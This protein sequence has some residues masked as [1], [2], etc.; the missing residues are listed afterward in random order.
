LQLVISD[1][2]V[3]A[4]PVC[5]TVARGAGAVGESESLKELLDEAVDAA[6]LAVCSDALR[7][8][9]APLCEPGSLRLLDRRRP[10]TLA[11]VV[12]AVDR[13]HGRLRA[14]VDA[15]DAI[16]ATAA[17]V[18]LTGTPRALALAAIAAHEAGPRGWYGGLVVE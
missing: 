14:G 8:D 6:S 7:N 1:R 18:M 11:T 16:V 10:M 5:G 12:H 17:P 9:L 2:S 13:L 15:W 4:L 3:Q